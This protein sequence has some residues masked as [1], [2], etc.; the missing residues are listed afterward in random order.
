VEG[1]LADVD[2]LA[3]HVAVPYVGVVE[4]PRDRLKRLDILGRGKRVVIEPNPH[5]LGNRA[6]DD[7]DPPRGEG[8]TLEIRFSLQ[9]VPSGEAALL[10]DVVQ[11][12]GETGNL[13]FSDLVKQGELR[14]I[15]M[16]NG[17]PFD[18]LNRH[19][20]TRNDVPARIRLPIPAGVLKAGEN[21]LRFEQ[22]GMKDDPRVLDSLGILNMAVEF[23]ADSRR[24]EGPRP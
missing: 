18:T 10:L 13:D 22:A 9:E 2:D 1:V 16:M 7:L 23:P 14:T 15:V 19:I 6:A 4:I 24:D 20:S 3:L 12:I 21:V 5:H 17:R 8:P 11:V